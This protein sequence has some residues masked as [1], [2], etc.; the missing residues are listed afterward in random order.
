MKPLNCRLCKSRYD[1]YGFSLL[2]ALEILM[3]FTF[4]G[5]V[6]IPPISITYAFIPILAAG[7][8]LGPVPATAVGAVFGLCSMYKA[9]AFYVMAGDRIFS[10]FMSATP[11]E[12]LLLSVGTRALFGL[13]SGLL[14]YWARDRRHGALL[15]G[16]IAVCSRRLHSVLVYAAMGL[17]FPE[18]N[19]DLLAGLTK[20]PNISDLL[21]DV[22]CLLVVEGIWRFRRS[23]AAKQLRTYIDL[24]GNAHRQ[25]GREGL[26]PR[27]FFAGLAVVMLCACVASAVY[28]A[29]RTSYMMA[30][31]GMALDDTIQY[32][33]LHLQTQFLMAVLSLCAIVWL[34][35]MIV[36]QYLLYREYLG[37][38]DGL[39]GIMGRSMFQTY[40]DRR[41]QEN[42]RNDGCGCFLFVDVDHFKRINDTM[43]HPAGDQ[44]LRTVAERLE[45]R[46]AGSGRTG[47]MGGDEFAVFMD[48]PIQPSAL[49][50]LLDQFLS[51]L[52]EILPEYGPVTCS[53]G[54]CYYPLPSTLDEVYAATDKL[55]YA[56]KQRGRAQYVIG[57]DPVDCRF[58]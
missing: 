51:D 38:M 33:L 34:L 48:Y 35:F 11:L 7:V 55:L 6:H 49:E 44:V 16:V 12:S 39:T 31:H 45:S 46:F 26:R 30:A 56:A 19:M 9:S 24:G 4:L 36:Y 41:L 8:L 52:T 17:F 3:S 42:T 29:R 40:C 57:G 27:R 23:A 5:Y 14:L 32:D 50:E 2:L 58:S 47:R 28:F 18:Q 25:S 22:V 15:L 53:I 1:R 10:P 54:A 20:M 43:G 13:S 37:Q 21:V